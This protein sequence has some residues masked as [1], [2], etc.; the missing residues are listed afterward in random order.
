MECKVVREAL[1]AQLDGEEHTVG[2]DF[3]LSHCET[4]ADCEWWYAQAH[5]LH[6][7]VRVAPAPDVPDL[8]AV[9]THT[10]DDVALPSEVQHRALRTC[11]VLLACCAALQLLVT[12]PMLFGGSTG[13]VHLDHELGSWDL[14][15]GAGLLFAAFRPERAWG[16]LPL[17][18]AV[19]LALG[20]T[21]MVD[22]MSGATGLSAESTHLLEGVGVVFLWNVARLTKT[23]TTAGPAELRLA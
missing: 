14:A 6:R 10:I 22:V 13:P 3:V 15:L 23:S 11:R 8:T 17:V 20:V 9:I 12:L 19:A 7:Q 18:A 21:A 5:I 4:C 1:S 16:M 2:T